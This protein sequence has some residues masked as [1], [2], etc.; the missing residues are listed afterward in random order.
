M[1][2]SLFLLLLLVSCSPN[3]ERTVQIKV[4]EKIADFTKKKQLECRASL[5]YEAEKKVDSIL[6]ADAKAELMD[7]LNRTKPIP[8]SVPPTVQPIDT[9]EIK[10][11]FEKQK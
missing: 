3:Q 9:L 6:L 1:P 4:A 11:I 10:P 2:R 7:S 5:L 8:P